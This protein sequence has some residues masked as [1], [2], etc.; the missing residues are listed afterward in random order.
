MY[1]MKE[2]VFCFSGHRSLPKTELPMI[3]QRTEELIRSLLDRGMTTAIVGGALGYDLLALRLLLE[4]RNEHK[5]LQIW[6]FFPFS[7]YDSKWTPAQRE[8]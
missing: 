1:E 3:Q 4:I 5:E 7:G 6:G 8:E 2:K